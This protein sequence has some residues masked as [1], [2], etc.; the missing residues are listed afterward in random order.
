VIMFGGGVDYDNCHDDTWAYDPAVNAWTDLKPAGE[1]PS[2]RT[3][4]SMVYD[5]ST[6][7]V[8]MF[9]GRDGISGFLDDT[10]AYDP[11]SNAWT[12]LSPTGAVP[13]V[14]WFHS[15]VY[16]STTGRVIMFGGE[17]DGRHL[18]NDTWA[19]DPAANT[20]TAL[21]PSGAL[22]SERYAHSLVYESSTA[23]VIM[24]GGCA[25][26]MADPL[27]DLWAYDPSANTW[28]AL[29]PSGS[30]P[31]GRMHQSM[32]YDSR[33]GR[34]IVFGG[35]CRD[36]DRNWESINDTWAYNPTIAAATVTTLSPPT[37]EG[38]ARGTWS[39][40]NPVDPVPGERTFHAMVYD[41]ATDRV[42]MFGGDGARSF[43]DTWAFDAATSTWTDLSP[44]MPLPSG[45]SGH[46]MA[47][48]SSTGL[49]I[50]FGGGALENIFNDTWAY[51]P[52]TN[53][54]T[55]LDPSG[56]LPEARGTHSMV[57]DPST[58][59]V[60]MFGGSGYRD[61]MDVF[62]NDTWAYDPTTNRWTELNPSGPLPE[63]RATQSMVYDPTTRRVIMFGGMSANGDLFDDTWAYDLAS[64]RWTKIDPSGTVPEGRAS[65]SMVYDS[66]AG[67]VLMFGG[68]S[69]SG[70]LNDIWAYD[71][72][73]ATWTELNPSG[74][75]P[76]GRMSHAMAFDSSTG[77]V[78][79]FGGDGM[80]SLN[81]TW[82]YTP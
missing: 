19:Y 23:R 51:D 11:A 5:P 42:I 75:L 48:D 72:S 47:Y 54:W 39:D 21:A 17:A 76:V 59:R 7:R 40:L 27:D 2:A 68:A 78:L 56:P 69:R 26:T 14:R 67:R 66:S 45:R 12:K 20:W 4:H 37:T 64:D 55:N 74:T 49:V 25:N 10:W 63:A 1:S 31:C 16:D 52:K 24:F 77:R 43:G 73:T 57:Y 36:D 13:P 70:Y 46:S 53:T 65:Q 44:S 41:P 34:V 33:T 61:N 82:A 38:P 81:D 28:S 18:L 30:L 79:M 62:L 6:R 32:V 71:P 29:D 60:I 50:M 3:G 15:M 9:G 58:N 80:H 35:F 22:P 8:I